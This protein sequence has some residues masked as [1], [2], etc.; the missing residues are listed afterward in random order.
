MAESTN[1]I[2][3]W[4]A[5]WLGWGLLSALRATWHMRV[6]DPAG[7]LPGARSGAAPGLLAFWHRQ[8]LSV[9]AEFRNAHVCVPISQSADGE[10]IAEVVRHTRARAVRGSSSRGGARALRG[11]VRAVRDGWSAAITLDGPRGPKFT[12]QP[13]FTVLARRCGIPVYPLAVAVRDAW[14]ANSWDEF[15]VPKPG[16]HVSLAVGTPLLASDYD[17][18][19]LFCDDLRDALFE[20]TRLARA[21][22]E[23][24]V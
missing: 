24:T 8:L 14:T 16:T 23:A 18:V 17:E 3:F 12:I 6:L 10:L 20:A 1:R 5:G 21:D 11:L 15:V 9:T 4:A 19:P 7:A 22:V 13:G 2:H